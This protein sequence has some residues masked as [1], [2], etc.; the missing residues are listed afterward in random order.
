MLLGKFCFRSHEMPN[1]SRSGRLKEENHQQPGILVF[2]EEY[3]VG[4]IQFN[5]KELIP[6]SCFFKNYVSSRLALEK[7][8]AH[9]PCS[10]ICTA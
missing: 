7:V 3:S 5:K 6:V 1:T 4:F 9:V 8:N 10:G 2:W